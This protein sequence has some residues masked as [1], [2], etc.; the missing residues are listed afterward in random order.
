MSI[1]QTKNLSKTFA[2]TA[3]DVEALKDVNL[4]IEQGEVFGMI[5]LSGAGKST[6]IR[7]LNLLERPTV[8]AVYF[9]GEDL[10]DFKGKALLAQRRKMSMV[11]Q[12]FNLLS[13]R[14][15]L[16]N[17][18]FPLEIIGLPRA[19]AAAKAEELLNLVGLPGKLTAYPSQLSGGQQQRVAIARAL[20]TD[21]E[22]LLC[23]EVT[24]ALD[25]TTTEQILDLLKSINEQLGVTIILITHSMDVV[26]RICDR[27][28]VMDAGQVV[29]QGSV[30]DIFMKPKSAAARR[31]VVSKG[32]LVDR[33]A[34]GGHLI[35]ISFDGRSSYEPILSNLILTCRVPVN[36]LSA[37]SKNIDG[38]AFG[39]ML[40]QI[41]K[42]EEDRRRILDYLD[43]QEIIYK[44]EVE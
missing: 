18:T 36:I 33:M 10:S 6:L 29:E 32:E 1:L 11:F 28:A 40:I 21:P 44:E 24:S 9:K 22:V 26:T 31:L 15:A 3:G 41:P 12:N 5:G 16:R 23:D 14:T 2:T 8:G 39:Q 34:E 38:K 27:V 25:P 30:A 17:V 35:R 43:R 4:A 19:E 7:C 42:N 37:D 13:Q 20:A